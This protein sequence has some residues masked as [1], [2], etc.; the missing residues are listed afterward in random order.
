MTRYFF[1]IR[2]GGIVIE[3]PDGGEFPNLEEARAQA[4]LSARELL[5][6]RL[7]SGQVLDGQIIEIATAEGAVVAVVPLKDAINSG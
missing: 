3:D 6:A 1:H 4:I 7:K 2:D 5:A